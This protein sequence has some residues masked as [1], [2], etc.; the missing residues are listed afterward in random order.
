MVLG[1]GLQSFWGG[2][3]ILVLSGACL[4]KRISCSAPRG[5]GM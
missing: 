5:G 4:E 3:L 1:D 2:K